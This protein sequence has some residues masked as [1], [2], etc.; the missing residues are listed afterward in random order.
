MDKFRDFAQKTKVRNSTN[1]QK[2]GRYCLF[3]DSYIRRAYNLAYRIEIVRA[4]KLG[5]FVIYLGGQDF[6]RLG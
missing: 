4:D 6:D 1:R 5:C 2:Y 3:V